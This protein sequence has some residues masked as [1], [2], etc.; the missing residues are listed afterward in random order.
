MRS[1]HDRLLDM[2]ESRISLGV[3]LGVIHRRLED[4]QI[5]DATITLDGRKLIDFSTC[6]Y[7]GLNRDP[8][9]KA[10]A[11]DAVE[12][13]GTSWSASPTYTAIPLYSMLEERLGQMTG[14]AV[15]IAQTTTLAHMAALPALI[16]PGDLA[17][18][19][20]RSHDSV[21]LATMNL[22]GNGVQV[23]TVAHRDPVVLA[24]RL[25]QTAHHFERVWYLADGIYSMYGDSAPVEDV[26]ALQAIYPNLYAY[27]DDAHG[28]G[29]A[30]E[31]GRGMVLS[32]VPLNERT[33]VAA[34]FAKAFG[35][36]GAVIAFGD[37]QMARR[38]RLVGGPLTFS[39]PIPPPDL[40]SATASAAIHLSDEHAELQRRLCDDI[41]FMRTEVV[42][43]GL[44]VESLEST[45][46][47]YVRVGSPAQAA[48]MIRRL[49][50]E[51]FYLSI[52][53]YPAVPVGQAGVRFNQS[54]HHTREHLEALLDA[55]ARHLPEVGAEP[56]IV[57]DLRDEALALLEDDEEIPATE[58]QP[59]H[60]RAQ[61][62][63][64]R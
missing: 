30:G 44:P 4:E 54:L 38:C 39:G 46:I 51:G 49:M 15:A 36:L 45:P 37:E 5:T 17:L 57:V 16:G 64:H 62:A 20:A 13:Y 24:H 56:H 10:A 31:H 63:R 6:S 43:Y 52:A 50:S 48:E 7:L 59:T 22:R 32:R 61:P 34:G 58:A 40:G 11:I 2:A 35:S 19:D 29:W 23:E 14:G 26:A 27:Y 21:H 9:L 60:H 3:E 1:K 33:V 28:F 41:E 47:W 25:A 18:V 42:R 55:V 53:A 8:R 12:R